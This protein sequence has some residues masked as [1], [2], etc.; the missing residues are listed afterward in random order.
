MRAAETLPAGCR[1]SLERGEAADAEA[2]QANAADPDSAAVVVVSIPRTQYC[3]S[4][5]ESG[6]ITFVD[7][8]CTRLKE[9]E[10]DGEEEEKEEQQTEVESTATTTTATSCKTIIERLL[11]GKRE[12]ARGGLVPPSVSTSGCVGTRRDLWRKGLPFSC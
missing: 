11:S 5:F 4:S 2:V 6:E 8:E 9:E 12:P 3:T 1:S 10:E 7:W